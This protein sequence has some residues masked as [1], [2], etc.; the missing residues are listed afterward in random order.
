MELEDEE[1]RQKE[2]GEKGGKEKLLGH[3]GKD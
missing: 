3:K 2:M 1:V